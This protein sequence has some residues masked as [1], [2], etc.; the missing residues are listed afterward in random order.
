LG[1]CTEIRLVSHYVAAP[2]S[3]EEKGD[4]GESPFSFYVKTMSVD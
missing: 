4:N 1:G 2:M 3:D